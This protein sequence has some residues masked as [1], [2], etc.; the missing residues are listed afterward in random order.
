MSPSTNS[1]FLLDDGSVVFSL[2]TYSEA[3]VI[4]TTWNKQFQSS[5]TARKIQL[6]YLANDILQNNKRKGNEFVEFWKVLLAALS[7]DV[8]DKGDEQG[9]KVFSRMV[10][11]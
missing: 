2:T 7:K 9:K 1:T 10:K 5:E 11:I 3:E 8:D 4:I 6:L